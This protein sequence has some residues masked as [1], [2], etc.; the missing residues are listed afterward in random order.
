MQTSKLRMTLILAFSILRLK[1]AW[2]AGSSS[3]LTAWGRNRS[4]R[5]RR[6]SF[7]VSSHG[8]IVAF[9]GFYLFSLVVSF[10]Q[11]ARM[12][13]SSPE[14]FGTASLLLFAKY[15]RVSDEQT[16]KGG[17]MIVTAGDDQDAQRRLVGCGRD[18]LRQGIRYVQPGQ[19][20]RQKDDSTLDRGFHAAILAARREK[21]IAYERQFL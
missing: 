4:R 14:P 5:C 21:S 1:D 15:Q 10:L 18:G 7:S 6:P 13:A 19:H 20:A 11:T 2:A 17:L 16:V 12:A 3:P 9:G 8:A